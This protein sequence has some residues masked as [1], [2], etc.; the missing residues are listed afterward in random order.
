MELR[1]LVAGRSLGRGCVAAACLVAVWVVPGAASAGVITPEPS[2]SKIVTPQV[3]P[4]PSSG[5]TGAPSAPA[6]PSEPAQPEES[7]SERQKREQEEYKER[8]RLHER[9]QETPQQTAARLD[10]EAAAAATKKE[11]EQMLAEIWAQVRFEEWIEGILVAVGILPDPDASSVSDAGSGAGTS[12]DA[13]SGGGSAETDG[14]TS[15][16]NGQVC[17]K[18]GIDDDLPICES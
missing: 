6:Q 1:K 2:Q 13:G 12:S 10:Q 16:G 15:D 17:S 11:S 4:A 7:D 3:A 14:S 5:Q 8:E 18:D 9:E